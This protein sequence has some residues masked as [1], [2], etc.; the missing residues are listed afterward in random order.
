MDEVS[1]RFFDQFTPEQLRA[2]YARNLIGL[3]RLLAKAEATG[4]KVNGYTVDQLR[5]LVA[6]FERLAGE[7]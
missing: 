2:Q 6:R 4:R 5:D 7:R 1:A 3:R